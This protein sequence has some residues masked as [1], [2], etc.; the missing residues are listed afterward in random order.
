MSGARSDVSG[1]DS[2]EIFARA[3]EAECEAMDRLA[4]HARALT[5]ALIANDLELI[6]SARRSLEE[7][8]IVH[9]SAVGRRRAMQQRGF[10]KRP[11]QQV[12]RYAP[13]ALRPRLQQRVSQLAVGAAGLAISNGNNKALIAQGMRRLVRIAQLAQSARDRQLG[14]YQRRRGRGAGGSF[15]VSSKA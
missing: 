11:L 8:R 12:I 4:E 2:W 13:R 6:E 3:L 5:E 14:T 10:G 15:L 9:Q 7:A 1:V